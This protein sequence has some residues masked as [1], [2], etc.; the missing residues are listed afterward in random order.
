MLALVLL[1]EGHVLIN[2]LPGRVEGVLCFNRL[3]LHSL[4]PVVLGPR[5][6]LSHLGCRTD[7]LSKEGVV[8]VH[9]L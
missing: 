6:V 9:D 8:Q 4:W 5:C 2:A 3:M 1:D 7:L